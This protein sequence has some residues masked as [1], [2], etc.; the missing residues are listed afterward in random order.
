MAKNHWID[1][2]E[3]IN[4]PQVVWSSYLLTK[5]N[6]DED[7]MKLFGDLLKEKWDLDVNNEA[8]VLQFEIDLE[9]GYFDNMDEEVK[10]EVT[11][12]EEVNYKAFGNVSL[13]SEMPPLGKNVEFGLQIAEDGRV[14]VCVNGACLFR[15]HPKR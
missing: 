12:Q 7:G 5:S 9:R 13:E 11:Q 8:E 6:N 1:N 2:D 10:A 3:V 14:W 15:F 4:N